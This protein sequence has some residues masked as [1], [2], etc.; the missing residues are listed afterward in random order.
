MAAN[1]PLVLILVAFALHLLGERQAAVRTGPRDQ[2]A[3]WRALTFYAGLLV[4]AAALTGPL[5]ALAGELFW[6]QMIQRLLLLAVAAP[7]IVLSRP[8]TSLQ[9][10]FPARWQRSAGRTLAR[11]LS[12]ALTWAPVAWLAFNVNMLFW[13]LPGPNDLTIQN[14]YV[15]IV[16]AGAFL[17]FAILF[18][19]QLTRADL[20]HS[21]RIGYVGAA[22]MINVG[23]AIFLAFAQHPLY[24][25]YAHLA[26]RAG[27]ISAL[28]DQQ[29]GAGIMWTAG[30][31]PFATAIALLVQR[32]L[33]T[34][35]AM[36]S[37]LLGGLD[38]DSPAVLAAG[39]GQTL[40][41]GSSGGDQSPGGDRG[42]PGR[43]P[44]SP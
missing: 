12:R 25:P 39:S 28:A 30:D 15:H 37:S 6:A 43:L 9:R 20:P 36:A 11:G 29:I 42:L 5:N 32:W 21:Q 44:P 23:L 2:R 18:W 13:H 19:A 4:I 31:M 27:G 8:W 38:A 22:M 33:A 41:A 10:P 26:R 1:L 16:E 7:L 3:R 35:E 34:Q 17:V 40:A 24:A 14:V